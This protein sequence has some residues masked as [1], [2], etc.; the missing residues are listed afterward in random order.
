MEKGSRLAE[1]VVQARAALD[2]ALAGDALAEA[3]R[4]ET[5]LFSDYDP[6]F[7]GDEPQ[8]L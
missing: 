7:D 3:D 6:H 8:G 1:S 4:L 2:E 5:M